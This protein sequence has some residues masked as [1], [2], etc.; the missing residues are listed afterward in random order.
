MSAIDPRLAPVLE[1]ERSDCRSSL[2]IGIIAILI[3][4][5]FPAGLA[6]KDKPPEAGAIALIIFCAL[7]FIVPGIFFVRSWARGPEA[8]R[9]MRLLTTDR[10]K[11][12]AWDVEY[13][14][15]NHGP[16]QTRI[17]LYVSPGGG[18]H[19]INLSPEP[20]KSVVDYVSEI[21][22]RREK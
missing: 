21:A 8:G 14:S 12:T 10:A 4:A 13:V 11:I 20:A 18:Y 15:I 6:A 2:V 7:V 5:A 22:P 19:S 9:I 3:G 17:K 16:T 1:S